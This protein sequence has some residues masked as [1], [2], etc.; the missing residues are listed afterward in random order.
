MSDRRLAD[1]LSR[2]V[3]VPDQ[4][5]NFVISLEEAFR[6]FGLDGDLVGAALDLGLP[7][8]GGGADLRLDP[9]DLENIGSGLALASPQRAAVTRWARALSEVVRD[10]HGTYELRIS[11]RCPDPGHPGVCSY[12]TAP[13]GSALRISRSSDGTATGTVDPLCEAHDFGPDFTPVVAATQEL[14]FH[15]I[16]RGLA[17]DI[18]YLRETGLADCRLATRHLIGV[19]RSL[20]MTVRPASGFFLGT[21]FPARHVWFEVRS[22]DRWVP[23]DPFFM[24][25]LAQWGVVRPEDWPLDRS[26]RNVL[27][28]LSSS[29][30][31]NV[32]LVTHGDHIAPTGVVARW[33]PHAPV[34]PGPEQEELS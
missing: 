9:L 19:A 21:P 4:H 20:G 8:R 16:P 22:G 11:W 34:R 17:E 13:L 18:G 6:G 1:L 33:V 5:R 14:I 25:T 26:P 29:V 31:V 12:D 24:R 27:W 2:V 28:R 32:P 10:Q 23:A 7:H 30:S 15:R 3:T